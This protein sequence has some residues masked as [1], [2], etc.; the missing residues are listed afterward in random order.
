VSGFLPQEFARFFQ[1]TAQCRGGNAITICEASTAVKVKGGT[2]KVKGIAD[3]GNGLSASPV[4]SPGG[5]STA[6]VPAYR[7]T[8]PSPGQTFPVEFALKDPGTVSW[9]DQQLER[10]DSADDLAVAFRLR[11]P[12]TGEWRLTSS[13]S[14][15]NSWVISGDWHLVDVPFA[16]NPS[17]SYTTDVVELRNSQRDDSVFTVNPGQISRLEHA[18]YRNQGTVFTA[19]ANPLRGLDPVWQLVSPEGQHATR[20]H[21]RSAAIGSSKA[22]A[23]R[24]WLSTAWPSLTPP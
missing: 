6:P 24:A 20:A 23:T 2:L 19:Y 7:Y 17:D 15:A 10:Y 14:Q 18:G 5:P 9:A 1:L 4:Y 22:G 11:D 13:S 16:T 8:Q 21:A 3:L 12:I